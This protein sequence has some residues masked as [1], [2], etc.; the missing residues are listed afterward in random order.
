MLK[1][2]FLKTIPGILLALAASIL[3]GY[4][5]LAAVFAVPFTWD[6]WEKE[7]SIAALRRE[8]LFPVDSSAGRRVDNWADSYS[9]LIASYDGDVGPFEQASNAYYMIRGYD[10]RAYL[11]GE[12]DE[13]LPLQRASYSR[14]WHGYMLTLRPMMRFLTFGQIRR[15]N[16]LFSA[17]LMAVLMILM[18]RRLRKAVLPFLLSL[19]LLAPTTIGKCLEYSGVFNVMLVM[20]IA[21]AGGWKPVRSRNGIRWLFFFGGVMVAYVDFLSAPTLA[22]CIPLG[23]LILERREKGMLPLLLSCIAYW[24][25]GYVGMWAGKWV[26]SFLF[27]RMDFLHRLTDSVRQRSSSTDLAGDAITRLNALISNYRQML[28]IKYLDGLLLVYSGILVSG[29]LLNRKRIDRSVLERSALLLIPAVIPACWYLIMANHSIIHF[30]L[31][32]YR[33]AVSTVFALLCALD[34]G[35]IS[36]EGSLRSGTDGQAGNRKLLF[37]NGTHLSM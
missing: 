19:L 9:L 29:C 25:I 28:T 22:L 24:G 34:L 10:P 14:Y 7:E 26:I 11:V 35:D 8:G 3:A 23:F 13:T 18:L 15:V 36:R 1:T 33:T 30:Y 37:R 16:G 31:H 5:F 20:C 12:A 4:L 2:L 17:F 21:I 27:Q 6:G 32:T